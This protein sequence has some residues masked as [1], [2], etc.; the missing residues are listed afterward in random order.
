VL[1][2]FETLVA[3]TPLKVKGYIGHGSPFATTNNKER[4]DSKSLCKPSHPAA[5]E[6]L[7]TPSS[8][9]SASATTTAATTT[10]PAK[11]FSKRIPADI[12]VATPGRLVDLISP[13]QREFSRG[14]GDD[15][16]LAP[17]I[18][19][20][21][22]S[23]L[24]IDEADRY[25]NGKPLQQWCSSCGWQTNACLAASRMLMQSYETW[26][27]PLFE[28]ALQAPKNSL[29]HLQTNALDAQSLRITHCTDRKTT[30]VCCGR[31]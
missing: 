21:H 18:S 29:A 25:G 28:A 11:M 30:P 22:L 20:E 23:Y 14:V 26:L 31:A 17:T 9:S 7:A 12:V 8:S 2:V 13:A 16:S 10:A 24:V 15:A 3:D 19:L 6:S 27:S 5:L 4:T 1:Q